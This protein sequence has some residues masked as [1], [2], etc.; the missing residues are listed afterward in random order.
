MSLRQQLVM[1]KVDFA[2]QCLEDLAEY[3]GKTIHEL[4][5][6]KKELKFVEKMI[7]E[8][9]DCLIDVN[10]IFLEDIF[11]ETG[12]TSKRGFRKLN[13]LY[14]WLDDAALSVLI[15]IVSLRNEI[16]H[17]Y[18]VNTYIIWSKKDLATVITACQDYLVLVLEKLS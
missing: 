11:N 5:S 7:Q 1:K 15:S 9:V 12:L 6:N 10:Q 3:R 17:S 4:A 2:K 8:L 14:S 13:D 16:V 18:D